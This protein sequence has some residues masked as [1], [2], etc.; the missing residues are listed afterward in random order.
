V[1]T[2][3]RVSAAGS[4]QWLFEPKRNRKQYLAILLFPISVS[5]AL[6]AQ[7]PVLTLDEAFNYVQIQSVA[8]SPDG[9]AVVIGTRRPN[10]DTERFERT[11]WLYRNRELRQLTTSGSDHSPVWSPDGKWI[12]FLSDR[13]A[14]GS[15]K[16]SDG[17]ELYLISPAGGE[18]FEATYEAN[19][20]DAMAWAPDSQ[21]IYFAVKRPVEEAER[22]EHKKQWHDVEIFREDDRGDVIRRLPLDTAVVASQQPVAPKRE[23]TPGAA[24]IARSFESVDDMAVSPDGKQI[25]FATGSLSGRM[26][27]IAENELWIAD[28]DNGGLRQLT[29]NEANERDV[30][31]SRDGK[32]ILFSVHGGSVEGKY[33]DVQG[34]IYAIDP[35]TTKIERLGADF[36]G[37]LDGPNLLN[38]GTLSTTGTMG[39]EVQVFTQGK[40]G[41]FAESAGETGT[42]AMLS[43]A[44]QSS[45]VAFVYSAQQKP[46]EVYVAE[47]AKDIRGARPITTFN[48]LFTERELPQGRPYQWTAEDGTRVEGWL[49]YPPGQFNAKHL[50]ML[51]LIHGGPASADGNHF[52]SDWY[53]WAVIAASHGWLVF[54]PNYRGSIGYGDTFMRQISPHLVSRPGKDIL[55]GVDALVHDGIA[56]PSHLT[57]GGYSYGGYM[58]NWLITQTTRFKAAVTGAGS[59]EHAANWG[60]DDLTFDDAWYLGGTPWEAEKNYND[61]A[62]V[63]QMNR[64]RTPTQMVV[65][66][67]DV[68][69]AKLESYLM[70]RELHTLGVPNRL[71]G[72]PGEGHLLGTNPW[73]GKIKVRE[74]LK[75]LDK[76]DSR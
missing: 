45:R 47:D 68:R 73:H 17:T 55:E 64:V 62:A 50:R 70:E 9:D 75:W 72:F 63:W 24:V 31:W 56:D 60:N 49:I 51:T 48:R 13:P 10:W 15:K 18:A 3:R 26:E 71:L 52:R 69:V 58:T 8:I 32:L 14:A 12:A 2:L 38:N 30:V 42:Y 44:A 35:A 28:I 59:V 76:Y 6:P 25:A 36:K 7:K 74:E 16:A 57:I 43:P 19:A 34:R 27:S 53:D 20:I 22:N 37:S 33:E 54:R 61:E 4:F 23:E 21:S 66:G 5:M 11:L 46:A 65:G 29:H 41:E 1:K 40:D 39:T 67:E